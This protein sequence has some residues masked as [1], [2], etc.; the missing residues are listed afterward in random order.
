MAR[1]ITRIINAIDAESAAQ[2]KALNGENR[3]GCEAR[4]SLWNDC[5]IVA[6]DPPPGRMT[7]DWSFRSGQRLE[8]AEREPDAT[9]SEPSTDKGKGKEVAAADPEL[10]ER[11]EIR[12][13]DSMPVPGTLTAVVESSIDAKVRER[14]LAADALPMRVQEPAE[15][16]RVLLDL[17]SILLPHAPFDPSPKP[18]DYKKGTGTIGAADIPNLASWGLNAAQTAA[19]VSGQAPPGGV[20]IV[21]GPPGTGKSKKL[22]HYILSL[23]QKHQ[24]HKII[25]CA[26]TNQA[27]D[28]IL[29]S[30]EAVFKAAGTGF[31][32]C[33]VTSLHQVARRYLMTRAMVVSPDVS[34]YDID[35]LRRDKA[36]RGNWAL[37]KEGLRQLEELGY[38]KDPNAADGYR[39]E[40]S[41][42]AKK[43]LEETGM[44]FATCG[45]SGVK[46]IQWHYKAEVLVID[47]AGFIRDPDV[48][49]P[50]A[51]EHAASPGALS[52]GR[53]VPKRA[54]APHRS[55]RSG[56][57]AAHNGPL[58]GKASRTSSRR[59]VPMP[60]RHR[61]R[62]E[63]GVLLMAL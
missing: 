4:F 26:S 42:L 31:P 11:V 63:S 41:A 51:G 10:L 38:I 53:P 39:K 14:L 56:L 21:Q 50:L 15:R 32:A 47:E 49:M 20:T 22:G 57:E 6:L 12:V 60:R 28:A 8:F 18:L 7:P 13:K 45:M 55:C 35:A 37:Y 36:E 52:H 44:F 62:N 24:S 46:S 25:V 23:R 2:E 34:S 58:D 9:Q 43:I 30:A 59:A 27:L 19:I 33:R 40:A 1:Y 48:V 54:R 5:L 3:D 17:K 61:C 16:P 29:A